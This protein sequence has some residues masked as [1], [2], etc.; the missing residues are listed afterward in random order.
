MQIIAY[1]PEAPSAIRRDLFDAGFSMSGAHICVTRRNVAAPA[2]ALCTVRH[3][4]SPPDAENARRYR[5]LLSDAPAAWR[6][7][8]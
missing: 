4:K 7:A 1:R 3:N 2:S 5:R 8:K 6:I